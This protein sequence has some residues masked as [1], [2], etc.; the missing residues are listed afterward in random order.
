MRRVLSLAVAAIVVGFLSP[1]SAALSETTP[2]YS[3]FIGAIHEH[4]G[5]SDGFPGSRPADY[6]A[7]AKGYG[8]DFLASSEHSDSAQLPM[9]L[10]EECLDPE[11]HRCAVAD[12]DRPEDSFRKWDATKEQALAA[13]D[14]SFTGLRGFEW[15]SDRFGHINV[16][17]SENDLNAY[18]DGGFVSM[19][20]FWNW[21]ARSPT[22]GGGADGLATFNHPGDKCAPDDL[23]QE[24]ETDP[25]YNWSSFEYVPAADQRMVG[26]EVYNDND[27]YDDHYVEALDAGWHV[28]AVGAEDLGHRPRDGDGAGTDDWGGPDWAKTVAIATDMTED[29]LREAL[30]ARRFYAVKDNTLRMEI[31]AGGRPMGSRISEAAGTSVPFVVDVYNEDFGALPPRPLD[32]IELVTNGGEIAATA[33][34]ILDQA[35]DLAVEVEVTGTD[36]Y[37]FARVV[38]ASGEPVAY[39]SPVWITADAAPARQGQWLAGDLHIHTTYS[40]DS[41]GGPTDDNTGPDEFYTLGHPVTSQFAIAIA[42]G[43]DY[44]AITDHNDIRSQTDPGWQFA[45]DNGLIPVPGYEDSLDGHAQVLGS[46]RLIEDADGNG[47]I[48]GTERDLDGDGVSNTLADVQILADTLRSEGGVFQINHPAEDTVAYPDDLDWKLGNQLVPDTVEV[49]N[50]SRLWQPPMPSA[51]SNDDAI[52]VWEKFLDDGFRVGATGG[53]DN[54]WVSTTAVQGAGQ[55]TTWVFAEDRT[56]AGVLDGLRAGR[57]FITHQP[58]ALGG[59]QIFLE[60]DADGDGTYEAMVGDTVSPGTSLRVRVVNGPG[61]LLE[62][63]T[64]GGTL[65]ETVAVTGPDFVH[66]FVADDGATW[67]RAQIGQ[68]DGQEI[69]AESCP[70]QISGATTYCRNRLLVVAMTSALFLSEPEPEPTQEDTV[71]ELTVQSHGDDTTLEARLTELDPPQDPIAGRR[72]DFYSDSEPIGSAVTD[73]NGIAEVSVPPGHRGANRTYEAVFEGDD[74]YRSSSDSRPGKNERGGQEGFRGTG[75][76]VGRSHAGAAL[77]L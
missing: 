43:L 4:S 42:R 22:L 30:L 32:R 54:H 14:D 48:E 3:H 51:S 5:Y 18:R 65:Q 66:D 33:P 24:C 9:T 69:R 15:S 37:Y 36:R 49:W 10:S 39:S 68:E 7:S 59:P 44:L 26:I 31:D 34:V 46:E 20:T 35:P 11:I 70:A 67:V 12:D 38:D 52:R 47:T 29:G 74:F 63:I 72:I 58:P 77:Y 19:E 21:F 75:H 57:T 28:G 8:L 25:A 41:Y 53:S 23:G 56:L 2:T 16:Y 17:L 6:Y 61:T 27:T 1:S 40:H 45:R 50:I 76:Q 64:D 60:G 62:M 71:L 73:S 55:P 13:T